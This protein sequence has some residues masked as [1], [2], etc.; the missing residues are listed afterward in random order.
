METTLRQILQELFNLAGENEKQK[1]TIQ[2]L[3][4]QLLS[5]RKADGANQQGSGD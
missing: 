5:A 1:Q 4:Q 3:Q 2:L